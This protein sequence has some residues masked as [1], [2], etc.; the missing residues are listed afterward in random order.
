MRD[1][2]NYEDAHIEERDSSLSFVLSNL[3]FWLLQSD[4]SARSSFISMRLSNCPDSQIQELTNQR[5]YCFKLHKDV[6]II[7]D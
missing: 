2:F 6:I 1:L 7:R 4:L 3:D 5:R